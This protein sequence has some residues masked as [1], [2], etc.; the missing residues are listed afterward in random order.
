MTFAKFHIGL[1]Y[2]DGWGVLKCS[3]YRTLFGVDSE[4]QGKGG[5]LF[6]QI[7]LVGL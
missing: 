1:L 6:L 7:Y 4:H 3:A 2:G 5:H